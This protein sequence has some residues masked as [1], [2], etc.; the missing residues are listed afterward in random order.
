MKLGV[1]YLYL[2]HNNGPSQKRSLNIEL[3]LNTEIVGH[4]RSQADW[5]L[6][7]FLPVRCVDFDLLFSRVALHHLHPQFE[8]T[9]KEVGEL[10]SS[11]AGPQ[12]A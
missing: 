9:C 11:K 2:S 8:V 12:V 1:L 3:A 7:S 6:D 10:Q 5:T 4:P